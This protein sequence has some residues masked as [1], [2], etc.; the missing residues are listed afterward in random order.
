MYKEKFQSSSRLCGKSW[1]KMHLC[2]PTRG[3]LGELMCVDSLCHF[4]LPLQY[5]ASAWPHVAG[6]YFTSQIQAWLTSNP[7]EGPLALFPLLY[8]LV[9]SYNLFIWLKCFFIIWINFWDGFEFWKHKS[10]V[11]RTDCSLHHLGCPSFSYLFE[12]L[13]I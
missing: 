10:N 13:L 2:S 11:R 4:S 12:R 9:K 3:S 7:L 8:W 5:S 6:L 1:E